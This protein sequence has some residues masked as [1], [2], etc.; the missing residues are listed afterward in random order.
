MFLKILEPCD[1][2]RGRFRQNRN[3]IILVDDEKEE[4]VKYLS[5]SDIKKIIENASL[6]YKVV[7]SLLYE[8]G[9]RINEVVN[10]KYSDIQKINYRGKNL[11]VAKINNSKQKF[12]DYKE[13]VMSSELY[14]LLLEQQLYLGLT[15]KDYIARNSR[16]G[17]ADENHT[18]RY[19]KRLFEKL[20]IDKKFA[21]THV[22]RH[23]RAVHLLNA[24]LSW[25]EL[26]KVLGHKNINNTLI[27]ANL[28]FS[29]INSKLVNLDS[30][31]K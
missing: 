11:T 17:R 10:L 16:K 15:S 18:N 2:S 21:H 20:G 12:K 1:F 8:L 14:A 27:Y 5:E 29:D 4:K 13:I 7:F 19:M 28:S 26:K 25:A 30:I 22:F 6:N 3:D 31:L 9:A 23:S 24:G